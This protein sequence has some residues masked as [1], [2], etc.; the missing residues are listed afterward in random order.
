M[1]PSLSLLAIFLA[2]LA[3]ESS[4]GNVT[5]MSV[6]TTPAYSNDKV[7]VQ[8]SGQ[9]QCQYG[10][11]VF[12]AAG[13]LV[14]ESGVH[15]RA[16]NNYMDIDFSTL[17]PTPGA[18]FVFFMNGYGADACTGSTPANVPF[19]IVPPAPPVA[20]VNSDMLVISAM[21]VADP[22]KQPFP[23]GKFQYSLPTLKSPGC[24]V[25]VRVQGPENVFQ[26]GV[27]LIPGEMS[28]S[29]QS[30]GV[31]SGDFELRMPGKYTLTMVPSANAPAELRCKGL[32]I[33]R[34]FDV[35]SVFRGTTPGMS[36]PFNPI[37]PPNPLIKPDAG[38][39]R[40]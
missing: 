35:A 14:W 19:T 38:K 37:T 1:K 31:K 18:Y 28:A 16:G 30:W 40:P 5:S 15:L 11:R 9:G 4:A 27:T 36:Q 33:G 12:K 29:G 8:F 24:M 6:Q 32:P 2:L 17:N 21:G 22:A 7:R 3:G 20:Q 39:A 25:D 10:A 13:T 34:A 26:N 23:T